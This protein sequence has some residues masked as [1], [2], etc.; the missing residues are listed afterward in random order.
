[1]A[2]A[3][4]GLGGHG[5]LIAPV[6]PCRAMVTVDND[7]VIAHDEREMA[8]ITL[9][10]RSASADPTWH[11]P[12]RGQF[13]DGGPT[14]A[15]A[16]GVAFEDVCLMINAGIGESPWVALGPGLVHDLPPGVILLAA[17]PDDED[18]M[19]ELH[20]EGGFNEFIRLVLRDESAATVQVRVAPDQQ[21]LAKDVFKVQE[22]GGG[23]RDVPY[24]EVSYEHEG[25]GWKQLMIVAPLRENTAIVVSAQARV[26]HSD[27][28]FKAA[29]QVAATL[30]PLG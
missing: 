9:G 8:R 13:G 30:G 27:A 5:L 7:L 16:D 24:T 19:Y 23:L 6:C 29:V 3:T 20:L 18:P 14:I 1:M 22:G 17:A 12:Q 10:E 28:L 11:T 2:S 26:E 25:A 15:L 4:F 21:L